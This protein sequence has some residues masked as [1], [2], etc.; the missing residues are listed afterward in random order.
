[1]VAAGLVAALVGG[2]PASAAGADLTAGASTVVPATMNPGIV[3]AF[4]APYVVRSRVTAVRFHDGTTPSTAPGGLGTTPMPRVKE[5]HG[6][7]YREVTGELSGVGHSPV[8]FEYV[9]GPLDGDGVDQSGNRASPRFGLRGIPFR[10]VYPAHWNGRLIVYRNGGDGG[11]G[12]GHYLF[13]S[14]TDELALVRRGYAYFVTLGGATTPPDSNPDSSSGR[15]WDLARPFWA[16]SGPLHDDSLRAA[17]ISADWSERPIPDSMPGRAW[18]VGDPEPVPIPIGRRS[19]PREIEM[20]MNDDVPTFRDHV[21]VAKN[22]LELVKGSR[23]RQTGSVDWS[24]SASLAMGADLG[25][26][27]QFPP[28]VI[29]GPSF[30]PD[31]HRH[32]TPRT[33]GDFN[34]PYVPSSG[35]VVDWFVVR[36]G[37]QGAV[38]PVGADDE[39]DFADAVPD[40]EYP[41]AAPFV[42]L[43]GEADLRYLQLNGYLLASELADALPG[44][45]LADKDVNHWLRLYSLRGTTHQ[46]REAW[47]AGPFNGGETNWFEYG[48]AGLNTVG[49]GA[50]LP[51]WVDAVRANNPDL[52]GDV[53]FSLDPIPL[54]NAGIPSEEGF[55]LQA[56]RNADRWARTGV[57]P[58]RSAVDANLVVDPTEETRTPRYPVAEPCTPE[59][60]FDALDLSCLDS[61]HDDSVINDPFA[62]FG[63]LD[64]DFEIPLLREF[65]SGPLRFTTRPIALPDVAVPLGHRLF[66][67]GP[68]FLGLFTSAELRD[69]Y[70]NH[71]GYA[72]AVARAAHELVRRHLYDPATAA[73]E[74]VAAKRSA[75][76]R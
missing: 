50:E 61:L 58:P 69:R 36:S 44:S 74:I 40:P 71:A 73:R 20:T 26:T 54:F 60:I 18:F 30:D 32:L 47:F 48:G 33:G 25:R 13:Q 7:S 49:R 37:V 15:F 57:A 41:I 28:S 19:F 11:R 70:R 63:P 17:T 23:P 53:P 3:D 39:P 10:L 62:E 9:Y 46:P 64:P 12:S 66:T 2:S 31:T 22:L 43:S 6:V 38:G 67:P 8:G 27:Q 76:L 65:A 16:P 14:V 55:S 59:D 51:A 72:H 45:S 52:V 75:V 29:A 34:S 42:Y 56:I 35:R 21:N 68:A 5:Q 4:G 1:M 24:R